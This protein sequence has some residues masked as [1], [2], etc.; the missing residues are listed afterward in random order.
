[1]AVV[2]QDRFHCNQVLVVSEIR[3]PLTVKTIYNSPVGG[4]NDT[5]SEVSLYIVAVSCIYICHPFSESR[6]RE[7]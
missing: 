6:L 4:L 5:N 1:M 3:P 7:L 2:S